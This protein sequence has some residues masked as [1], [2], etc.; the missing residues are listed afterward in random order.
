[1]HL[2]KL[3]LPLLTALLLLLALPALADTTV[4]VYMCGTDLQSACLEDIQ[5]M[6]RAQ[7]GDEVRLSVLAG[8]AREW[9]DS[10]FSGGRLNLLS[11]DSRGMSAIAPWGK[12]NMGDPATLVSFVQYARKN[13]PAERTMLIFWD[14]GG[15][16]QYGVCYDEVYDDDCLTLAEIDEA[17]A[18][19][20]RDD[21]AFRLNIVGMDACLMAGF[22]V[23]SVCAPY[24]DYLVASQELEPGIGWHYTPWLSALAAQPSMSDEA[25][26][27]AVV[28]AYCAACR[29]E[30]P[31][32]S[33]TLSAV[34]LS[35][36]EPLTA[37]LEELAAALGDGLEGGRLSTISR[38]HSRMHIFGSFADQA[39]DMVD[40][41][42]LIELGA[43]FNAE[44]AQQAAYALRQAVI[45]SGVSESVPSVC[46]LSAF[47][48]LNDREYLAEILPGYKGNGEYPNYIAFITDYAQQAL[49]GGYAFA[50]SAPAQVDQ[51]TLS[52]AAFAQ[53]AA[54]IG[55]IPGEIQFSSL[56]AWE[57]TRPPFIAGNAP[58]AAAATAAPGQAS[59]S[60]PGFIAG[61]ASAYVE[62]P[63]VTADSLAFSLALSEDAIE[64]LNYVEGMLLMDLSDA[65]GVFLVDMGYLQN[66]WIDWT[67]RMVYSMFDG[68]WP[69]LNGQFVTMY[70]QSVT[71][72]VRRSLIPVLVN[73]E[74]TYLIVSFEAE[75]K[76]GRILGHNAGYDERGL[77]IRGV[78][79][80]SE[81]D[82]ITPRYTMYY[83]LNDD[84]DNEG[85]MQSE[86]YD[87]EP[88]AWTAGMEVVYGSLRDESDPTAYQFE[89]VLND[90]FGDFEV[91]EP[92]S[93][94][95]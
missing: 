63:T 71:Q 56:P 80:L 62:P 33:F 79:R 41:Q 3:F 1:M 47:L 68:E 15:G 72:A 20:R 16:S 25:L 19:L 11:I 91:S 26:C 48:P 49:G 76:T 8:G 38:M 87:G 21:P 36:M 92:I 34:R 64:N 53:S 89:F 14:H 75:S 7:L 67:G 28:D 57:P 59:G 42:A 44:A 55:F 73:G 77:P 10:R 54:G 81:G 22:E 70:D 29:A 37:A 94:T 61:S 39:S 82:I 40:L 88:F 65:D 9:D 30:D 24:A 17:F 18:A 85:E 31:D 46:G 45:V 4:M 58:G 32:D 60:V 74:E 13:Y 93:F 6:C 27:L 90:I 35:E 23:A 43:Q 69:M 78:T 84:L 95:L 12:G 2:K 86:V 66:S 5:E 52:S 51:A 83:C 50:A